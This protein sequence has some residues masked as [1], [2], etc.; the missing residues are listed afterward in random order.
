MINEDDLIVGKVYM[1]KSYNEIY[2]KEF[3]LSHLV[4]DEKYLN[5]Y[6]YPLSSIVHGV[7]KK[8]GFEV[9]FF[10]FGSSHYFIN[11]L[12]NLYLANDKEYDFTYRNENFKLLDE[13]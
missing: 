4:T 9:K 6:Y 1:N 12:G 10:K 7:D 3:L 13:L 11:T 2:T 8:H 5:E